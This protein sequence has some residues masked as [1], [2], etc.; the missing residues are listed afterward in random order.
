[1]T[2]LEIDGCVREHGSAFFPCFFFFFNLNLMR[3]APMLPLFHR[4]SSRLCVYTDTVVWTDVPLERA[5]LLD[6][7]H[8]D[9]N[10]EAT[11]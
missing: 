10:H 11:H 4:P 7:N 3:S 8:F 5:N 6:D 9:N 1:M 2:S